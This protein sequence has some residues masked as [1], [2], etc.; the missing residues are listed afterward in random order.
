MAYD[1]VVLNEE[2]AAAL[3]ATRERTS[4]AVL[5][6]AVPALAAA[7]LQHRLESGLSAQTRPRVLVALVAHD[8]DTGGVAGVHATV[9]C[10]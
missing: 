1:D 4:D 2:R 5:Q 6:Q 10:D 7:E 3:F 9:G 8:H